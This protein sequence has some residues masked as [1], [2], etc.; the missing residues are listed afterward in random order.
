[1]AV[2]TE[3]T[4]QLTFNPGWHAIKF[5]D[6]PWYAVS[7]LSAHGVKAMDVTALGPDGHHWWIEIKD[8]VGYEADNQPRLALAP[9]PEVKATQT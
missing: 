7:N 3:G 5:D 6:T 2:I 4:L 9:P 1:M 8:C